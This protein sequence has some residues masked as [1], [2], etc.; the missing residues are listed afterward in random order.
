MFRVGHVTAPRTFAE[1]QTSRACA[2]SRRRESDDLETKQLHRDE[3]V[4]A[5]SARERAV[6][7]SGLIRRS[8]DQF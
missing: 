6:C 7:L 4:D 1:R 5:D 2:A 3:Q 8:V